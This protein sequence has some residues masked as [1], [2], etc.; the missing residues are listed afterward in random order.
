[1]SIRNIRLKWSIGFNLGL[2]LISILI[3]FIS[4]PLLLSYLGKEKYGIWLTIFSFVGWLNMFELGLGQGLRLK[5][6]EAFSKKR[7]HD[8]QLYISTFY[9]FF[10]VVGFGV[11]CLFLLIDSNVN[12]HEILGIESF[13]PIE[14]NLA[15]LILT[16]SFLLILILKN[17]G[18]I[19]SALQ[20]SFIY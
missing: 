14:I 8:V 15:I 20:L 11:I 18:I 16:I 7:I 4:V 6:T 13:S 12:W 9:V 1:M 10:T 2:R 3:T 19:F 5:L 17:I